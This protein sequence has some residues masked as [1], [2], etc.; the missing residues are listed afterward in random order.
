MCGNL[1]AVCPL[2]RTKMINKAPRA[3]YFAF[4][5]RQGAANLNAGTG[6]QLDP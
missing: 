3:Y 4:Y 2:A 1:H 5:M 6:G